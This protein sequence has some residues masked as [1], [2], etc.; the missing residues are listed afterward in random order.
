M[1]NCT[2][3]LFLCAIQSLI[4]QGRSTT[5]WSHVENAIYL[6]ATSSQQNSVQL[7]SK[8]APFL[9]HLLIPVLPDPL[10]RVGRGSNSNAK[11]VSGSSFLSDW[12]LVYASFLFLHAIVWRASWRRKVALF[13]FLRSVISSSHLYIFHRS[14]LNLLDS[15]WKNCF[16]CH[17][18]KL[19]NTNLFFVFLL[20]LSMKAGSFLSVFSVNAP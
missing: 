7:P 18:G 15:L 20:T 9:S 17:Q 2:F 14:V 12:L 19:W 13:Y 11:P 1:S 3:V 6:L 4:W 5:G 16:Y 10:T 8:R